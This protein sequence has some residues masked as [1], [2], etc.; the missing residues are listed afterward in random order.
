M[1]APGSGTRAG[2]AG[3]WLPTGDR[4]W[5]AAALL[6]CVVVAAVLAGFAS[7][8]PDGLEWA[9]AQLGFEDAASDSPTGG[10]PL[11]DYGVA[12]LGPQA[13]TAVAGIVGVLVVLAVTWGLVALLRPRR[14]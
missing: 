1:S 13:G 8:S 3:R 9:A 4:R 7:S 12:G 10:S 11:A 14:G 2:R 6:V 5:F